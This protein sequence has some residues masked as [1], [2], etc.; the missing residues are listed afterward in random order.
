MADVASMLAL[1]NRTL[2]LWDDRYDRDYS[3]VTIYGGGICERKIGNVS[4]G[5]YAI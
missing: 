2:D 5:S 3:T 4:C 1:S